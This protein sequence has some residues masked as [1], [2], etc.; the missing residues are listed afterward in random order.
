MRGALELDGFAPEERTS[1]LDPAAIGPATIGLAFVDPP[2]RPGPHLHGIW[3]ESAQFSPDP[4]D[5]LLVRGPLNDRV[6][7]CAVVADQADAFDGD[8]VDAPLAIAP[9]K[10]VGDGGFLAARRHDGAL[11][12]REVRLH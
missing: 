10:A 9:A 2:S 4:P 7:L 11:H 12:R 1:A 5:E 6:E 8:V 3:R